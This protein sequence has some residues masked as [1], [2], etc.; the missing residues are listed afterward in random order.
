MDTDFVPFSGGGG[1]SLRA[2]TA[3]LLHGSHQNM[4]KVQNFNPLGA[5]NTIRFEAA[6]PP[7]R[8]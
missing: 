4:L 7:P 3:L 5:G 8:I 2:S 6:G 1:R